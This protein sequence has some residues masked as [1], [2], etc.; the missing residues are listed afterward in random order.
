LIH[1]NVSSSN[2]AAIDVITL[3]LVDITQTIID[4]PLHKSACRVTPYPG[5]QNYVEQSKIKDSLEPG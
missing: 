4:E 2:S 1:R 3:S 5:N